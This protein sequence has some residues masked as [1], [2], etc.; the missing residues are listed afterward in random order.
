MLLQACSVTTVSG[1]IICSCIPAAKK[2][3]RNPIKETLITVFSIFQDRSNI[4]WLRTSEGGE[5]SHAN[6][7]NNGIKT[8]RHR[9]QFCEYLFY[10]HS[11]SLLLTLFFFRSKHFFCWVENLGDAGVQKKLSYTL[12]KN[13]ENQGP[14]FRNMERG[15]GLV[16]I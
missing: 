11:F 16:L 15:H 13:D 8:Y 12:R 1:V 4:N 7:N 10:S 6:P 9:L 5:Q 14:C 2:T 3:R